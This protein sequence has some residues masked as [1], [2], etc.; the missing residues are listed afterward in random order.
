MLK[1]AIAMITT[2]SFLFSSIP[3]YADSWE[4]RDSHAGGFKNF[5]R[6]D[7]P[8]DFHR[9]RYHG[10]YVAHRLPAGYVS[11]I[12]GGL[13]LLY[14]AG[15][16]YRHSPSG[17]VITQPPVGAIVPALPPGYTTVI[18]NGLPYYVSGYTYYSSVPNGY[19]V[20][21]A[22]TYTVPGSPVVMAQ[23][24]PVVVPPVTPIS[25]VAPTS[26]SP[27]S[28]TL[29]SSTPSKKTED[30]KFEIYI[31]N[32]DGTFT[33]VVLKETEK[34]FLGPQ[35]EFY[36]DHPTVDELKARYIKKKV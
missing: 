5:S 15:I 12:V 13:S 23:T 9:D 27:V 32:N 3:A 30:D 26:S 1:K 22:P 21:T 16:F 28:T 14:C 25:S 18:V 6:H 4:R 33:L 29:A 19:M 17:Y 7:I 35:G 24:A 36:A 31:P 2:A 8:R 10:G 11:L 34:G 20:V